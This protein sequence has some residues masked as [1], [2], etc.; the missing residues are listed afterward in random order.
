MELLVAYDALYK[1]NI[2]LRDNSAPAEFSK[3]CGPKFLS[4]IL[5]SDF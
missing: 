2:D 1:W 5:K 4:V 3:H